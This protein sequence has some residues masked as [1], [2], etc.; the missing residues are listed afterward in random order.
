MGYRFTLAVVL[1]LR[2]SIEERDLRVLEQTQLEIAHTIRV[3]QSIRDQALAELATRECEL[4][5]GTSGA[6]LQ[7]VEGMKDRAQ[8]AQVDVERS[9]A[10]LQL[11]REQQLAA[12]EASKRKR[13]VLSDL[14]QHQK[15]AY[16]L[17]AVRSRQRATDDLFLARFC[18][19]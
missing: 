13:E 12:Y 4:A 3:L 6:H 2:E 9:L 7:V 1:K 16:E 17:Q 14:R 10:Q 11:R 19:K 5:T 8:K 15:E 18:Q